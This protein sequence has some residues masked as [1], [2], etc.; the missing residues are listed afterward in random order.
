MQTSYV[1][2]PIEECS[3]YVTLFPCNECAKMIIQSG[4]KEVIY[5][6]DKHSA[7]VGTKASKRL[8]ETAGVAVRRFVP[9]QREIVIRLEDDISS[10]TSSFQPIRAGRNLIVIAFIGLVL[11]IG[12]YFY[13]SSYVS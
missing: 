3:I 1:D 11:A 12:L 8:L 13:C 5:L 2:A 6:S 4:I 9:R 7:K 10:S